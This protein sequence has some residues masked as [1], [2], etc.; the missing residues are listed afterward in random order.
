MLE[1]L[2]GN[3]GLQQATQQHT[4]GV[5]E[6]LATLGYNRQLLA[7]QQHTGGSSGDTGNTGLQQT[8]A[9]NSA[10]HRREFWRHWQHWST[11]GNY[12]Q[13]GNTQEG[14]LETLAT[15]GYNGHLLA[16]QQLTGGCAGNS[17]N[18]GLPQCSNIQSTMSVI[19]T[20]AS[21]MLIYLMIF[22]LHD[23]YDSYMKV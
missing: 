18:I 6:R 20:T 15:L 8:T 14:V 16:T 19:T 5:V 10:T 1:T 3:T 17:G 12:W 4:G 7:T 9:G 2:P 11:T 21:N 13:L 22:I 23:S